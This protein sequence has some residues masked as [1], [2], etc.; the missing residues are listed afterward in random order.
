MS[1]FIPQKHEKCQVFALFLYIYYQKIN[2]QEIVNKKD[3]A[4][5][6]LE[7]EGYEV[8]WINTEIEFCFQKMVV[9]YSATMK[10]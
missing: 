7:T 3:V 1:F 8:H 2:N 9:D 4:K 6:Q 5:E 10:E